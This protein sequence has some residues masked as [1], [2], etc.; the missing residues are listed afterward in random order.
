[1]L[2]KRYRVWATKGN[3]NNLIGM[4]L[5]VLSAPADT[6]SMCSRWHDHFHDIERLSQSANPNLAIVSK[7]GTSH[8]GILGSREN[9]A[10]AKA[11]IVQG[12]CAAGDYLPLLVLGGEDDFTPFIRDT[13]ARPAGIDVMLAGVSDDERSAP[14]TFALM[15]RAVRSLRSILVRARQSIPCLPSPA[16]SPFLMPLRPPRLPIAWA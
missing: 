16:C 3:F 7:I 1:M 12:M 4:P 15:T 11:E 8:I 10:R 9:I 5:T 6:E 13:F 14:A 2:A